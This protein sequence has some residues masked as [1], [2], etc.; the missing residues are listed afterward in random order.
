MG[1]TEV[2]HPTISDPS[3]TSFPYY[4]PLLEAGRL[5]EPSTAYDLPLAD[6][7]PAVDAYV[8]ESVEDGGLF[9]LVRQRPEVFWQH[10][11]RTPLEFTVARSTLTPS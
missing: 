10:L 4:V 11:L 2:L 3:L 8:R 7:L 1:A 5:F 6:Q 9:L